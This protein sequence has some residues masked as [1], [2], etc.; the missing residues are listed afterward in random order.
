MRVARIAQVCGP[1][2]QSEEGRPY[3]WAY[4]LV[5]LEDVVGMRL[6]RQPASVRG[7]AADLFLSPTLTVGIRVAPGPQPPPPLT[8]GDVIEWEAP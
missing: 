2:C 8:P 6:E 7:L 5:A 4:V 3:W 1:W